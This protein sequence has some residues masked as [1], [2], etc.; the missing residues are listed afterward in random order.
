MS[1]P[2][3]ALLIDHDYRALSTHAPMR[4]VSARHST[5]YVS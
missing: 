3:Y 5:V 4:A 2:D 1:M